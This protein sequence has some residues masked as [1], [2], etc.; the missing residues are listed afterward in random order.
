MFLLNRQEKTQSRI[1]ERDHS[2]VPVPAG[3]TRSFFATI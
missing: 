1:P 2:E 3:L